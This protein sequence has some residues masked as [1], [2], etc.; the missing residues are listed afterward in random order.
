MSELELVSTHD[1]VGEL[2]RR[3]DHAVVAYFRYGVDQT[4]EGKD[5]TVHAGGSACEGPLRDHL[6]T[7]SLLNQAASIILKCMDD[8]LG[9]VSS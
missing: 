9:E 3:S 8:E 5:I 2:V 1:L 7:V 4:G 6:A